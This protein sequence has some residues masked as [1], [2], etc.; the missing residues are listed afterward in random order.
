MNELRV[1]PDFLWGVATSAFQIEGALTADGRGRSIWDG[2]AGP[3]GDTGAVACDF[4]RRY[5]EDVAL[6]RALG[7]DVF[8]FSVAWPRVVPGG[9]GRVN[10]AGLDF[11]DRLVDALLEAGVEPVVTLFHWDL[12]QALEDRGGWPARATAEAFA[13]YAA[14][15]ADRLGDRV[16]L[17][18]THNEPYCAAWLGYV[19]GEHAPGR[20]DVAAGAAAAHHVLLSHGLAVAAIRQTCPGAEVGIVL[21]SWPQDA[22][23]ERE[24]DVAAARAADG[25]RNRLYFDPLLRGAYPADVLEALGAAAPPVRDGD[26]AT[27]ATPLDFLGINNYSRL[28]IAAGG[29]V[30]PPAGAVTAMGWEIH[31]DGLYDVLMRLHRDYAAPPLIVTEDGAAFDD[32]PDADGAIDDRDR[33]AYLEA[34]LGA[35]QRALDDGVPVRG[36]FV[37][38]LLDNF[39][40]ACGYAKRFGLVHVDYATQARRPKASFAWYRDVIAR[41]RRTSARAAAART[42]AGAAYTGAAAARTPATSRPLPRSPRP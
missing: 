36:H 32:V 28:R 6:L 16:R 25:I 29:V 27:I 5:P 18:T 3:S 26:L 30:V 17:W 20:R 34:Y 37:W 9:T 42:P 14:I 31:P 24:A 1:P 41:A 38:S 23:S 22:A 7:V 11:Y 13:R 19:T 35:L 15:V 4:Y 8:R 33:I 10:H 21:D 40:W 39:E 12:P 2:F